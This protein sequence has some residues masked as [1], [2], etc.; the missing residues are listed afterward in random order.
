[1]SASPALLA[2]LFGALA[3]A[4]LP[5]GAALGV[6]LRPSPRLTAAVMAFGAGAL[7]AAM[8]FELVVPA[9]ARAGFLPLAAGVAAGCIAFVWLNHALNRRGAFLRKAATL[10]QYARGVKRRRVQEVI[11]DL[12]RVDV[13]RSLPP[14]EVQL[15]LPFI[16][17]ETRAAGDIVFEQGDPGDALYI[18]DEGRIAILRTEGGRTHTMAHLTAGQTFG[19]MALLTGDPRNAAAVAVEATRL[20]KIRRDDFEHLVDVSP[21]LRQALTTLMHERRARNEA[22]ITS[23]EWRARALQAAGPDVYE[24]TSV[25]VAAVVRDARARS[26]AGIAIWLGSGLDGVAESVVIGATTLGAAVSAPLVAGVFLANL[27]EAMSSAATMRRQ[28]MGAT[29]I[30]GMWV[31]LVALSGLCAALGSALL[32]GAEPARFAFVEGLAAG[33]ILSMIAQTMLPEA[34][35]HGGGPAVAI[36]TVAGFL[37][38]ILIGGLAHG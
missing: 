26:A 22:L 30:V 12:S 16:V 36:M 17:T 15:L 28:G 11:A 19:E 4:S 37:T 8:S 18:L 10:G 6:W 20:W 21:A 14:E 24:P 33:A 7:L 23:E 13:F 35:D 32:A 29:V 34:F 9:L 25:D 38:S 3:A 5:L 1:M 31:L 2:F 27:P